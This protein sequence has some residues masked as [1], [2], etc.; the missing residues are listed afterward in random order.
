MDSLF[1]ILLGL[2]IPILIVVGIVYVIIKTEIKRIH[3]IL[4]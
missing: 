1:T 4:T 3:K 2:M